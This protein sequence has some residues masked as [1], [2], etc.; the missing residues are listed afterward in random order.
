MLHNL[1]TQ[2]YKKNSNCKEKTVFILNK[3]N[4]VTEYSPRNVTSLHVKALISCFLRFILQNA[5]NGAVGGL[6]IYIYVT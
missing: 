5:D 6:Y 2:R 1:T 3:K 4:I